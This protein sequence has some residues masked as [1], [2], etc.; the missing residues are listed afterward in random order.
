MTETEFLERAEQVLAAI[1]RTIDA[2]EV[3]IETS[4]NDNVLTLEMADGSKVVVNSQAPMQQLW[5]AGKGGAFHYAWRDGSW[6]DTR[7]GSELYA[8]L[9]K[10]VSAQGGEPVIFRPG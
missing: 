2:A 8:A 1:E 10:L 9:S 3:D 7:D 6:R 4:R 5:I